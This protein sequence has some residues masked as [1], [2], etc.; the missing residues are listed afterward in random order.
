MTVGSASPEVCRRIEDYVREGSVGDA[1]SKQENAAAAK[2]VCALAWDATCIFSVRSV[3]PITALGA[4]K[5]HVVAGECRG[6][7]DRAMS[8]TP[9]FEGAMTMKQK[10]GAF[11]GAIA[12][13]A[14]MAA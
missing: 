12:A 1:S 9:C 8:R 5:R 10:T 6:T 7:A 14:M 13:V 4:K 2:I 11:S 3:T